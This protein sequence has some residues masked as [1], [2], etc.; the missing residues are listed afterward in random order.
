[1]TADAVA[2]S[3]NNMEQ[4]ENNLNERQR[5]DPNNLPSPPPNQLPPPQ[6]NSNQAYSQPFQ[7]YL[8]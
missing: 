6:K 4:W 3:L 8:C 1:M 7:I 2:D 5:I